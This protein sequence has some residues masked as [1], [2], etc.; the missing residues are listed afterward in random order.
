MHDAPYA[1]HGGVN[2]TMRAVTK[3]F[4]WPTVRQDVEA[5]V[6]ASDVCQRNKGDRRNTGL[7][8]PLQISQR[9]WDSVGMD[10][11][12]QLPRTHAGHDSVVVFV[13]RLT[14]MVNFVPTTTDMTAVQAAKLFVHHVWRLHGIPKEIVSDRDKLFTSNFWGEVMRM[15]GTK[16]CMST[17]FHPH[18]HG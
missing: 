15:I 12:T 14:K 6:K 4:W 11:I 10:F 8:R 17:A 13:D 16:L 3:R 2:K 1:G 5:Y 18:S 7:L 9:A